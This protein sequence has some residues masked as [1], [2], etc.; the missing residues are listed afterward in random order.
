MSITAAKRG[1]NVLPESRTAVN[2]KH[3][4]ATRVV[5]KPGARAGMKS[6]GAPL[7]GMGATS[8]G[9]WSSLMKLKNTSYYVF[10]DMQPVDRAGLVKSG[11]P[12]KMVGLISTDMGMSKDRFVKITGLSRATTNRKIASKT[13]FSVDESERLV[14]LVKL[15]GQVESIVKESGVPAGFKAAK[16]FND[17]IEQPAPALGG[18]KPE[19][20]LDTSDG[21]EAV[22]KLLSQ[23]QSGA[24]A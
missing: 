22:S 7:V 24:Y 11:V 21:R 2:Q 1:G 14:G 13:D 3:V 18:L 8:K 20:L 5:D 16:W 9:V 19:E 12:S 6:F 15:I 10:Y 17:W 23:I 4:A